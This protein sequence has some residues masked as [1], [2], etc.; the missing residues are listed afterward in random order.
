MR[1][2]RDGP[3]P[4][5][6]RGAVGPGREPDAGRSRQRVDA[7]R[8]TGHRVRPRDRRAGDRVAPRPRDLGVDRANLGNIGGGIELLRRSLA[9]ATPT[10]DPT[11]VPRAHA[12]LGSVLEMGGLVDEALEVSLAG[13]EAIKRYSTE[14]SFGIFLG[15]NAAAYLIELGRYP[16]AAELLDRRVGQVLPGV[17]TIHLHAT[18]AHL[19]VRTGDL[20]AA[21]HHLDIARTEAS[22]INDAQFVIDLQWFGTEIE[23][24][25]GDPAAALGVA[26]DGFEPAGGDGRRGDLLGQLAMPA[27]HAAAD[28]AVRARAA[29]DQDGVDR[30]AAAARRRHRG[31]RRVDRTAD[32]ARRPRPPRDRL[33]DGRVHGRAATRRRRGRPGCLGGD[34]PGLTARPAPFL[35]AYVLWRAAEAHAVRGG[36]GRRGGSLRAAEAIAARIGAHAL[37][38]TDRGPRPAVARRR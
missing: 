20:D 8:R 33:A 22:G 9:L 35:E 7:V 32:R 12:N 21:R 26:L 34:P 5:T 17:S 13:V 23:L 37:A 15:C 4:S 30:A 3:R 18:R 36:L 6:A 10:D 19:A 28:L 38:R 27:A 29:R 24:W 16:E 25:A 1:C 31:L 2:W 11:V 14:L